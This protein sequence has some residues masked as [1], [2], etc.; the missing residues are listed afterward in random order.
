MK[1]EQWLQHSPPRIDVPTMQLINKDTIQDKGKK[2]WPAI[3]GNTKYA[4]KASDWDFHRPY[5]SET[6]AIQKFPEVHRILPK[7]PGKLE[8]ERLQSTK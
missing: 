8:S 3:K 1:P 6:F 5:E 7:V 4:P 2:K